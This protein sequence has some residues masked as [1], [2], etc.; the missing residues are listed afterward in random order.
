MFS[1]RFIGNATAAEPIDSIGGPAADRQAVRT[2][3]RVAAKA[4]GS[5]V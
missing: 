1:I 2:S 3:R 5:P 4:S